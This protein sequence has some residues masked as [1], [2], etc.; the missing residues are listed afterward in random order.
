MDKAH[1]STLQQFPDLPKLKEFELENL[2]AHDVLRIITIA[3]ASTR[4]AEGLDK[5][6]A[7]SVMEEQYA[8]GDRT[9]YARGTREGY[10]R[11]YLEGLEDGRREA[12]GEIAKEEAECVAIK[13]TALARK[14]G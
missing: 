12:L 8:R 5:L 4:G 10:Q 2:M 14:F 9:G 7:Q 11:G 3:L 1:S 6:R 13:H